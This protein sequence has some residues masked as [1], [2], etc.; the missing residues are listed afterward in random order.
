MSK[1]SLPGVSG[2]SVSV[3][4]FAGGL[5]GAVQLLRPSGVGAAVGFSDTSLL[6]FWEWFVIFSGAFLWVLASG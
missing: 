2:V 1:S 6:S 5:V 4:V 3:V